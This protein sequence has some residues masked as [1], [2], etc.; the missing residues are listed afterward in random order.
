MALIT[1]S[2][3]NDIDI[4]DW[5]VQFFEK[6]TYYIF[7]RKENYKYMVNDLMEFVNREEVA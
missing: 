6:N 7:N 2:F 5:F 1:Y 3:K 4:D